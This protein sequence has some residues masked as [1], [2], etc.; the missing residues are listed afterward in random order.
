MTEQLSCIT[1]IIVAI[2][3]L[4]Y[5]IT[6]FIRIYKIKKK[7]EA[8]YQ[9]FIESL[10]PNSVWTEKNINRPLNPFDTYDCEIVTIIETRYNHYGELWVR[11]KVHSQSGIKAIHEDSAYVFRK[12]YE[13]TITA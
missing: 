8:D 5:F 12:V 6:R 7:E 2:I 3:A 1:A 10:K 9:E 4:V 13:L 11:Y